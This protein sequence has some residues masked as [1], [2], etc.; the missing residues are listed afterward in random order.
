MQIHC[1]DVIQTAQNAAAFGIHAKVESIDWPFIVK[2]AF[3]EVDAD[4]AMIGR[5][6]RQVDNVEVFKGTGRFTG[7]KTIAVSGQGLEE[8]LTAETILVA[9]GTRPWVPDI[10]GLAQTLYI[11]FDEA[12]RL[13]EQP[14][15]LTVVGGGYIAAELAHFFGALGTEV[16]IIHRRDLMLREENTDVSRRFT[17][18]YQRRFNMVLDAQVTGVSSKDGEVIVEVTT[19]NGTQS[20]TS[21]TLLMATGRVPNTDLLDM[22]KTGVEL[23][24]RGYIKTDE[25]LQTNVPGIWALGDIVGKYLLKHSA[26]LEAAYA[27]N[28]IMNPDNQTAVDYS[29]MPHAVFASPQVASVGLTEQEADGRG[30]SYITAP[31]TIQTPP[32]ERP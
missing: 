20:I 14:R 11:T 24:D 3:E 29:A 28:N 2:R 7:P 32:T 5:G 15:R 1:G 10:P 23:N 4:A 13:P 19:P 16:T 12:L 22:A 18:V 30:A 8:E 26:N 25:F 9:A 31:I 21:D 17:E 6:N 27:S